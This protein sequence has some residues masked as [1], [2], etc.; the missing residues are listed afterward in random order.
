[1]SVNFSEYLYYDETSPSCLRWKVSRGKSK[2]DKGAGCLD[3]DGYYVVRIN[4]IGYRSHRII[5]DLVG[6]V[7]PE[8][9][10]VDHIDGNPNN[11]KI[12]NLRLVSHKENQHNKARTRLNKS[13]VSGVV[14]AEMW[15]GSRTKL[16]KYW[17]ASWYDIDGKRRNKSV[18]AT[19]EDD[20]AAKQEA[21]DI[22][23]SKIEWLNIQGAGYTERHGS[24][25]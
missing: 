20:I 23:T 2:V 8:N 7:I 15:N 11:N 6:V 3:K 19:G 18:P 25:K 9:K 16:L 14:Y 17:R 13:G 12:L 22:R 21:M 24:M 5:L 1:M 10:I 4:S